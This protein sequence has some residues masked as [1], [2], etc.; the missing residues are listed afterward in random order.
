M[1]H[2][3]AASLPAPAIAGSPD[4]RC[5]VVVIGAGFGG[6]TAVNALR[7]APVDITVI[8]RRNHHLFQPLLYQV[9]TAGL[10]PAE[11]A[12][13]IRTIFRGRAD[14]RVLMGEVT[15]V[16]TAQRLV[17]VRDTAAR[18]VPYDILV[19]ATGSQHSYFGHDDW[20]A[21][22]PGLKTVEDATSIRRRILLSFERAET[23]PDPAERARLLTFV[24][25]GGGPTGVELAGAMVELAHRILARDFRAIDP[26]SARIVLLEAGPRLL[27]SF[28]S[29]LSDYAE[30]SLRRLGAQVRLGARVTGIDPAGVQLGAERIE[31]STVIWAAGVQ[32]SDA[33][34]WLGA[35]QDR[36][37]RV[38]VTQHLTVPAHDEIFVIGD[39]ALALDTRGRPIPGLAPAAKEAGTYVGRA[40]RARLRGKTVG[41]FR[42]RHYGDLAT[43]GRRAAVIEFGRLRLRGFIAWVL[44]GV[45]HIF[46]LIG[47][48]NRMVVVVDWL[49]S[50][51]WFGGGA[52]LITGLTRE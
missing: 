36:A 46:F 13:P 23:E 20:E 32:A 15:G 42:Y 4:G 9:A 45:A 50:Y 11:I 2:I 43:I 37:G 30:R 27:P 17:Q 22:A 40:I 19:I 44:W 24:I 38:M 51:V 31:S 12:Y 52:R 14:V 21:V 26:S 16:D 41:P 49:W 48:R 33:G 39:T 29:G 1:T 3:S 10:S 35:E 8:D 5:R 28:A 18:E 34:R 25:V 47:F 6:I 7:G